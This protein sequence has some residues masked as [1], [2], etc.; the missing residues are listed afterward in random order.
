MSQAPPP[1][2]ERILE[3]AFTAF[4]RHGYGGTSTARI[5][6]LA[7]VSKRDL[8]AHFGSK[9][10]ML[11]ECVIERSE[12]MRHQL[13]LPEPTS[14][15]GLNETLVAFGT[16]MLLEISRP[17]V[18]ATY[19]LAILEVENA[20]DVARTLD[21]HGREENAQAVIDLLAAARG[22]GLLRG[23]EP[24]DMSG[25]FMGVLMGGGLLVRWLMRVAA[26][27]TETEARQRAEAA[28]RSLFRAYGGAD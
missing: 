19:R 18:L 10:A 12:R 4:M 9:Q 25:L 6:R 23:G 26:P 17:E 7:Q 28:A 21:R 15:E 3:A 27:P 16:T 2:R 22:R 13:T 24:V 8:Y 1:M 5:A 11:A 20:P 14:R